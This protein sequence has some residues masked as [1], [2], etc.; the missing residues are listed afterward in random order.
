M[1]SVGWLKSLILLLIFTEMHNNGTKRRAVLSDKLSINAIKQEL[2]KSR[3]QH[4][5]P[6]LL[7]VSGR[8]SP[9]PTPP[10][11]APPRACSLHD[12]TVPVLQNGHIWKHW[13][14]TSGLWG[15]SGDLL[16]KQCDHELLH[17]AHTWLHSHRSLCFTNQ[18]RLCY[19]SYAHNI[20]THSS[21]HCSASV[22]L[23]L[24]KQ[25]H[26]VSLHQELDKPDQIYTT[27][28]SQ[29]FIPVFV[30]EI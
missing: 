30:M 21:K 20:C 26:C 19:Y 13:A 14:P 25:G 9:G 11:C 17:G 2:F 1:L 15:P 4:N 28:S 5:S 18:S 24:Q 16:I 6:T 29:T 8:I 23:S 27:G 7:C 12:V 22:L 3:Q 10:Q